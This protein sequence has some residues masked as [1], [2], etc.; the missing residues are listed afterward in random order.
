MLLHS[1]APHHSHSHLERAQALLAHFRE[2]T[3][4]GSALSEALSATKERAA[5]HRHRVLAL[6]E[7]LNGQKL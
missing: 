6:A 4:E 2:R 1:G 5:S 3:D 7:Q